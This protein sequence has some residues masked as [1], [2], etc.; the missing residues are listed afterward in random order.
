MNAI[1]DPKSL[2]LAGPTFTPAGTVLGAEV[3]GVD[4]RRPLSPETVEALRAGLFRHKVLFFRDQ[5]ISHEDHIRFG[6][7][8]GELEAKTLRWRSTSS[9]R[10]SG[11]AAA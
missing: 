7:Y 11:L 3:S 5:D 4:L 8:F 9:R 1:V 10:A 2:D 6:R